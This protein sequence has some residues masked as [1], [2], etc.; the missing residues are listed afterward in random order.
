MPASEVVSFQQLE[1]LN[2]VDIPSFPTVNVKLSSGTVIFE[3]ASSRPS[4]VYTEFENHTHG[5]NYK[6]SAPAL[7]CA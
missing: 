7:P 4:C 5:P 2:K 6:I 3:R 1:L